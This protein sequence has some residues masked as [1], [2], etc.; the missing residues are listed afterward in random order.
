MS[1]KLS[2]LIQVLNIIFFLNST[3]VYALEN[4]SEQPANDEQSIESELDQAQGKSTAIPT[5]TAPTSVEMNLDL[6]T[7][8]EPVSNGVSEVELDTDEQQVEAL[9]QEYAVDGYS[10]GFALYNQNYNVEA[11]MLLDST[12]LVDVSS[13]SSDFQSVGVIG[14]YSVLP[15]N[16]VGTDIS[17]SI[18]SSVNHGNAG[19]SSITAVKA[20][21]NLGYAMLVG[22]QMPIY[23]LAGLGYEVVKGTDI[24]K[25]LVPGGSTMQ[26]GGG[27]GLGKKFN[28]EALYS[29]SVHAVNPYFF[30]NATDAA[31]QIGGATTVDFEPNSKVY[32]NIIHTRITYIY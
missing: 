8:A 7:P 15:Y 17:A 30:K 10:L 16:K 25:I 32:S 4:S 5:S 22:A 18:S 3:N 24:E 2:R 27:L 28:I 19:F 14:R 31:Q 1:V 20:E 29:Y 9:E 12:R 11:K 6:E 21:V 13:G 26:I 23:F